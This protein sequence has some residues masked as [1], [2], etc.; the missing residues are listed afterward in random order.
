MALTNGANLG[1]LA[2][3][4]QGEG[5]YADLMKQWR[6]L[7]ALVMPHVKDKDLATP[8]GS[9]ADGDC[10]IVGAAATGAWS[11]HSGKI[12]R[13]SSVASAWE[14]YTPK[15]GWRLWVEDEDADYVYNGSAWAFVRGAGTTANRPAGTKLTGAVYFDTT[16]GKPVWWSGSGWVDATGT[17]A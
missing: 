8:P 14:F 16:L 10:Y 9:P 7:D 2:N 12:A 1:L 17:A 3:G 4:A 11:T 13:W 15:E 5:H 6:G